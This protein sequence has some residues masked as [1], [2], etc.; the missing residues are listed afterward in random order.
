MALSLGAKV[1]LD[2][3]V[4]VDYLRAGMYAEWVLGPASGRIRLL[5]SVVL[6]ELRLGADTPRRRRAV[7]RI[8]AAFP[9]TRQISPSPLSFDRAGRLFSLLHGKGSGDRLGPMNDLLIAL[10]ARE[11]GATVVTRNLQE[12]SRIAT[13]VPGLSVISP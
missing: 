8:R 3:N 9:T 5:S 12:F 10:T 11:T 4:F 1:V 7:E 2:T 6:L 13:A